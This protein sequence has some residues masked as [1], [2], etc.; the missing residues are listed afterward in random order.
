MRKGARCALPE[1]FSPS[2]G[3]LIYAIVARHAES[4]NF[5]DRPAPDLAKT[6]YIHDGVVTG[7]K[8]NVGSL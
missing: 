1:L 3:I 4:T 8:K 6:V 5:C 7:E 2:A